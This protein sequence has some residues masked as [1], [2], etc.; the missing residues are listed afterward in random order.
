MK[1]KD[2]A[3]KLE[4]LAPPALAES[5]DNVGLLVGLPEMEVTGILVALD[6]TEAALEEAIAKGCNL[7]VAHHPIWFMPRKKLNGEDYVSRIIMRAIKEDIA[8]YACHTNLDNIREG[9]NRMIGERLGI[10]TMRILSPKGAP[11]PE[12]EA[13]IGSGMI[14]ELP[15]AMPKQAFLGH[16]QAAFNCGGIRY[17]DAGLEQVKTVAWCGGAG[18]FLIQAALNAGAH[19]LV[20]AD[21][22]YHKYFENEGQMLLLDIGHYESEQFTSLLISNYL[23]KS[24]PNFAVRLSEV[25]SNPLK[26]Y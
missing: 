19:A 7:L 25:N 6:M 3:R 1:V 2:I 26:Y 15:E 12:G 8:L 17:A 20:T 22:T 16:V 14:G 11:N 24:F 10:I 5:Y 9:V 23:S 21:I 13:L 18:S 4:E